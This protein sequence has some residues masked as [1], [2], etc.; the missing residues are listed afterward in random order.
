MLK[1]ILPFFLDDINGWNISNNNL[2]FEI[3]I[4]TSLLLANTGFMIWLARRY[5]IKFLENSDEIDILLEK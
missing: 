1:D 2:I 5:K 3:L 4:A